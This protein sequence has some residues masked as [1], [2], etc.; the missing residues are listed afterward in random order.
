MV[1]YGT[2]SREPISLPPRDIMM[3]M[4]SVE[5]F[6]LAAYL[7]NRTLLQRLGLL[8]KTGK[9][10]QSGVLGTPVEQTYRLDALHEAL[11]HARRP[12]R[13]GKILLDLSEATEK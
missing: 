3:P 6:Y 10:I 5:G 2:L 7:A 8:R 11:A 13:A 4:T 9:L 1:C 12:G